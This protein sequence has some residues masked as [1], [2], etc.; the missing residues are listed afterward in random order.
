[1]GVIYSPL[2]L[3]TSY[4]ET[5]QAH[6]VRR[7]R[8]Q[9]EEDDDTVEE[10]EQMSG[11]V[12][13]EGEGWSKKVEDSKPNVETDAA[14][15]ELRNCREEVEALKGQIEELKSLLEGIKEKG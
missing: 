3:I 8:R 5:K 6:K 2:L 12:D 4:L 15:L 11:E 14:V 7:N 10:W 13:F 9:G 1:M